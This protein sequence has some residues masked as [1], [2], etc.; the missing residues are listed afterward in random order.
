VTHKPHDKVRDKDKTPVKMNSLLKMNP[1]RDKVPE[2]DKVRG[3]VVVKVA[4][5]HLSDKV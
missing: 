2:L 1:V 3:K 5:L 4:N